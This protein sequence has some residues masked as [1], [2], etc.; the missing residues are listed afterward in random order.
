[1][2][3]P[4][5]FHLMG[6][7]KPTSKHTHPH[8]LLNLYREINSWIFWILFFFFSHRLRD[9]KQVLS[10]C[11]IE[12]SPLTACLNLPESNTFV[13]GTLQNEVAL[14]QIDC[15]R[16]DNGAHVHDD[17]ITALGKQFCQ[18]LLETSNDIQ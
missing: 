7:W 1:M 5:L 14:Y 11:P 2:F 12:S 9:G 16:L 10:V 4:F 6:S 18:F 17:N 15:C 13:L 3:K 8:P